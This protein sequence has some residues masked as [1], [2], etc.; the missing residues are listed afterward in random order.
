V[1]VIRRGDNRNGKN[2]KYVREYM[3]DVGEDRRIILKLIINGQDV[4]VVQNSD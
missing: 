4:R 2:R 1:R 3:E